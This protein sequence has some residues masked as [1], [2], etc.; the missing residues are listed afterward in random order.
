MPTGCYHVRGVVAIIKK[1]GRP[2]A[3]VLVAFRRRCS[4]GS[5]NSKKAMQK[6]IREETIASQPGNR[7]QPRLT[8]LIAGLAQASGN[9]SV[10]RRHPSP[11][12]RSEIAGD[13]RLPEIERDGRAS[14]WR[15]QGGQSSLAGV[16]QGAQAAWP[17]GR[18]T[19]TPNVIHH[20][21]A[22]GRRPASG[23]G[24]Q[25]P[26]DGAWPHLLVLR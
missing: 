20:A 5:A 7:R 2:A 18:S 12:R 9:G 21:T 6:I 13:R 16:M 15:R 19:R 17:R 4:H 22:G 25:T 11:R 14:S 1:R 3:C 8:K 24:S 10:L 26:K 23:G